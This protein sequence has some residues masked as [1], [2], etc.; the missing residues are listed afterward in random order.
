[1]WET[2]PCDLIWYILAWYAAPKLQSAWRGY[3]V[4]V[5]L[6]R[7]RMLRHIRIFRYLNPDVRVFLRRSRL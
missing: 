1:M 4:R 2:L 7:F 5:L 3:R 6:G